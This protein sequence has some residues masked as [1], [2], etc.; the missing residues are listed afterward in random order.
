MQNPREA[1]EAHR[2]GNE[3]FLTD[4]QVEQALKNS[5]E[6][7]TN[8]IATGKLEDEITSLAF[9]RIAEDYGF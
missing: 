3:Y 5:V 7:L 6:F 1:T 2:A 8:C 9:G 4:E